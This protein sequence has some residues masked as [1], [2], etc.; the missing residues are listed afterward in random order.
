V[1]PAGPLSANNGDALNPALL[2]GLGL[3]LQPDFVVWKQIESGALVPVLDD[4]EMPP[5]ALHLVTPPG[6]LRPARVQALID[7]LAHELASAPW[8]HPTPNQ[9]V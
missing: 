8:S 2:A 7:F 9:V 4:W 1:R 5:I 3:A 6:G